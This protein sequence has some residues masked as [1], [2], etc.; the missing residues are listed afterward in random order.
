[1]GVSDRD[2]RVLRVNGV[3][4]VH[5]C[6]L[7]R[8]GRGAEEDSAGLGGRQPSRACGAK[9]RRRWRRGVT[10]QKNRWGIRWERREQAACGGCTQGQGKGTPS[11]KEECG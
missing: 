3:A 4:T 6:R 9:R 2:S 11:A 5:T 7:Q 8:P 1:M 10:E